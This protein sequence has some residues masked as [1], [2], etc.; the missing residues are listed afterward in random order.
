MK[1]TI[2][3]DGLCEPNN[4][5]PN[6]KATWGFSVYDGD[7]LVYAN[8]G[9]MVGEQ[10]NNTAEYAAMIG[11]L[12]YASADKENEYEI[13]TDSLLV[14]NQLN[15]RWLV[16]SDRLQSWYDNAKDLIEPH[17][18]IGWVKGSENKADELTRL[19]YAEKWGVY[20]HPREKGSWKV[21][22]TPVSEL[23]ELF[24]EHLLYEVP[25]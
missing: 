15:G 19:A 4:G 1:Y 23:P 7:K 21:K 24:K 18:T 25:F 20:P 2:Y 12:T 8:N 9:A 17:I 13:L 11:G 14:V 10:T 5:S 3:T 16:K 22:F 6:G